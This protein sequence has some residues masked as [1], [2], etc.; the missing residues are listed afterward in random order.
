MF[1]IEEELKKLPDQ[2]GVYIMHDS[3]DAIIYIG[4]AVSL[5]KRVHQ[6]FQPSHDEGIKKAQMVKQIARFEYIV[7]D[8]ELEALVLECNLIKEHRPK[9]NTMLRDDK[10]YPYIRVT[11][12]EDFPRVL[13]S[14][15]QKKDKSRYFGP[16][17]S[18]GAVKDTIELVNKIYQLRTCN[19]NLP[20]DTGKDRPCLNYHIHQCTAPCQGY[21]TKEAYRERVDAVVEFLNGNYAPVLKSLEEKMNTASANLEFEKAIEYRELLNSVRQIA[22]KQKITHTDGEDK[23]IIALAAD[24]RDAVVQVFFIRDGKLIGR[25]HFYVKIGTEDT[26]AQILTTFIKQFYSGTPFIPREIMLPQEIEEQEVLADWL[27]EKRGSKVYI[28]VPQKGM[29]EKLVELA[30]KNAKMVLAQDREKIKREEGRTIGALKEIEQL[31]DMKGL[32]R[33]EA[34]DIS[35]TSGFESVG[36]MIVYEKGK[37][38]RSD[39][40]KFK[41]RTVSGPDDYASMYEVLTRRFTHG[42]REMEEMEE[43]DLS[44]EYGSFTRFPDLIMMDGGRGQVN[45]ALKVLEEL[46]LNIPVCGMVKDDN[47]RTRGLYYHNVEIPIDRGSEGFKL[48][49]RIQDEA[50]R[51]AIEYHRSL[52]SKEQVHSVLDD[53]PDIGP[54]RRKALM[55]KY[56]SLEAIR[57]A[58]E[59]DLAQTD[60]MSPQAARSVY[61]FFREKERENQPSD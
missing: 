17:T 56:Q 40:R 57:E 19:R 2:P 25:D 38:K 3:R 1:V 8:S 21:I 27:G 9:Y 48:I 50:H 49:T 20:R 22:Q 59:E 47:H 44:E 13:F 58:T 24:D 11:L 42:M 32:H 60:S 41:L 54:A 61:R 29:K 37:P 51:F 7:T 4:K 30:Q 52:R 43:K 46:H 28:R 23:D 39:Y 5:R 34:Y 12:G 15:Q 36:S 10:T 33:V 55:K 6:Y 35:T 53:I 31:L 14:R 18:A 45:I 26:K 16:Y